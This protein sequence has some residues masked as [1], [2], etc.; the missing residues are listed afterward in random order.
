[1]QRRS[2]VFG[3]ALATAFMGFAQVAQAN[4]ATTALGA[5]KAHQKSSLVDVRWVCGPRRCAW[6][7]NYRGPVVVTPRRWGPP[8]APHCHYV[9]G[10]YRWV[11]VCK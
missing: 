3:L 1:M 6:L 4:V 2:I 9:R 10:P 11:L 7:P 8:P 5:A